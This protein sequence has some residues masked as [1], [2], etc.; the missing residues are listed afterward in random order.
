LTLENILARKKYQNK[1]AHREKWTLVEDWLG[2]LAL[3]REL[4]EGKT[5]QGVPR[6]V[7]CQQ[8]WSDKLG[9]RFHIMRLAPEI[10]YIIYQH[11]LGEKI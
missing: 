1:Y 10:R 3:P 7:R 9:K 2:N 6:I 5:R 8:I 11:V 4:T